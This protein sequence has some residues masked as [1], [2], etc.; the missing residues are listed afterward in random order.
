MATKTPLI[1]CPR[2]NQQI[3]DGYTFPL[4]D[5][6]RLRVYSSTKP[7]NHKIGNLQKGLILVVNDVETVGEGTGFGLPVLQ[8]S[9]ETFFSASS[10]VDIS[11]RLGRHV[12]VKQFSMDRVARNSF[13]N[14]TLENEA[15]RNLIDHL[16]SLYQNHPRF[17]FLTLKDLT[18]RIGI[19]KAFPE[20]TP[21]GNVTVTYTINKTH[22]TVEAD[23][24][25][26]QRLGLEKIFMLNEQGAEFFR[27]YM[28]SEG[29]ELVDE[30]IGAWDP[31]SGEWACMKTLGGELGFRLWRVEGNVLR[32]GR[33]FLHGSLNWVG[34]D[35]E[36]NPT[37]GVFRYV[38]D[39]VGS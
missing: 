37:C 19:H 30:K 31:A 21:K 26:L 17:R 38:I 34:L 5:I 22:V 13:R 14:V 3:L 16:S 4:S 10:A 35:Y 36:V 39:I 27:K 33:E 11:S 15:A 1:E 20:T 9:H 8:Y 29:N 25:K 7:H 24:T 6:V 28:D 32:R 2:T 18:G 23:L 12:V